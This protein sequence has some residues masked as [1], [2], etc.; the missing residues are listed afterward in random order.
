[1]RSMKTVSIFALAVV[2]GIA[3]SL[4]C[5]PKVEAM[6]ASAQ[7]ANA[8]EAVF[9]LKDFLVTGFEQRKDDLVSVSIVK[10]AHP[11]YGDSLRVTVKRATPETNAAQLTVMNKTSVK[12]GD[13]LLIRL[14]VRGKAVSGSRAQAEIL[15]EKSTSPW[16]KS[17][18]QPVFT[19]SNETDWKEVAVACESA[20]DYAPG[21]V[22]TSVRVAFGPQ[23]IELAGL[24]VQNYGKSIKVDDL[25]AKLVAENKLGAV[26]VAFNFAQTKQTMM[27]LGGN[28]CQPRYGRTE[29]L[30]PVGRRALDEL[31]PVHARVGIPLNHW[32][33]EKGKF[34]EGAQARAC[35]QAMAEFKKRGIPIVASVWEGPVWLQGGQAEQSG[36][37]LPPEKYADCIDGITGFLAKAKRDF[38]VEAEYFSFNEPDY[39]VN[40]KFSPEQ[41]IAFLK[42]T[43][44]KFAIAGL[45]TKFVVGDTANGVNLVNFATPILNDPTLKPHLGPIAFHSWDGLSAGTSA[46]TA[47]ADLGKKYNKEVWCLEA[48]HD[49]QLWQAKNPW[50][51]W[52]NAL[53][54]AMAYERTIRLTNATLMDY[55]TY[56]DNYPL[57]S[58]DGSRPFPVF[59]V[60]KEMAELFGPG[61]RVSTPTLSAEELQAI[62]SVDKGGK[63]RAMLINPIGT[64]SATLSGLT[65]KENVQLLTFAG[66]GT[67]TIT[68]KT[69][70]TDGTIAVDL[71]TQSVVFLK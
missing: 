8:G 9:G 16:T 31:K 14:A 15:F 29:A 26:K 10:N 51:S 59:M 60:M 64:G 13:V 21:Q 56:Q 34:N 35:L 46:Y 12:K 55:W 52:S 5:G 24:S 37:V 17:I 1:M 43:A 3:G 7:A 30:D 28:F 54:T 58:A 70:G 53:R 6:P 45:K 20:E 62:G 68:K 66:S 11:K 33:P 50:E 63:R 69:V 71:P 42:Q 57:V 22:M 18:T 41:M 49:A 61:T 23:T 47:I 38:G 44:K 48:G 39:G 40:F 65:P 2:F 19:A 67:P 32:M 27:G 25:Q 4:A 36:R